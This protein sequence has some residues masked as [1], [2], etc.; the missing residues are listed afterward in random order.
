MRINSV[1]DVVEDCIIWNKESCKNNHL[2]SD[3]KID[4]A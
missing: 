3:D 1:T 4:I 2:K